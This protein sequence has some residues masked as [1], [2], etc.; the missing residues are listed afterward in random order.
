MFVKKNKSHKGI[1]LTYT[2]GYRDENGKV[3]HKNVKSLGYLED[4]KKIYDDPIAH[5]KS[6]AKD[7]K[8]EELD[9]LIIEDWQNINVDFT[10]PDKNLGYIF[11][12]KIYDELGI[13]QVLKEKQKVLNIKYL[14][15]ETL[16]LLV[17]SRILD[18]CSKKSTYERK[19]R[20]FEK[21]DFSLDDLYRSLTN[22][23]PLQDK[24]QTS[25]WENT[26]KKYNRDTSC[27]YYDC[28]NYYFE[29]EYN[30]EDIYEYDND[31]NLLYD[32]NGDPK[33]LEKGL[34]KRGPEKNHRP[35]PIIEMGLLMD[36]SGFP[37]SYNL[38][39][40][41]ESEKNSLIPTF[42]KTKNEFNLERT[43]IVADRGLNT[44]D[45]I[46]LISGTT[47]EQALKLNGYVYGQSV[48]GADDEFKSWVLNQDGYIVDIIKNDD[49]EKIEFKHQSRVYPKTMYVTREDKGKTKSGN[50]K[51]EKILV[52]QKQMVYYSQKYANK[53]KRDR[54]MMIKKANDL[55]AHPDK[56]T[57][58][59]SYGAA[60][61]VE[62]LKFLKSTGEIAD[63]NNLKLNLEKIKEE[64][65]YDGYY[66][67]VTSEEKLSDLEIRNIY[68]G[69]SKIEET[70]KVTKSDLE[71]RPIRV[72]TKVHI[73]SHFLICFIALAILRFL[74]AKL[75][76][77]YSTTKIVNAIKELNCYHIKHDIY[78]QGNNSEHEQIIKDLGRIFNIDILKKFYSLRN[79]KNFLNN[80]N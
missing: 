44:S 3:K 29:I 47:L 53:Q 43:I 6:L 30:D 67:I 24:I 4:L 9:K 79:I 27:T 13:E 76:Y 77:K 74:Q 62:N 16:P 21:N 17:F 5:F 48:R 51:R 14:L 8:V 54:E 56:Y 18:P 45:N 49:D 37:L 20:F 12:K 55:I 66:S 25:I 41:N 65:K 19:G 75:N 36:S 78:M 31:G 32:E 52:D 10:K 70:F 28:T 11:L 58:S 46:I 42:N 35:D 50:T 15:T 1:L 68:K 7:I 73:E 69:L 63:K 60:G 59:T 23:N 80:K 33:I 26:N 40:G 39:P 22:I 61:Y 57:R 2:I 34:R 38:F 72:S 64:E 71:V